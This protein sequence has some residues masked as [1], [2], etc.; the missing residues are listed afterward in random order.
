MPQQAPQSSVGSSEGQNGMGSG[1][2]QQG[3]QQQNLGGQ[4]SHLGGQGQQ[5]MGSGG[6]EQTGQRTVVHD[7]APAPTMRGETRR[8]LGGRSLFTGHRDVP[9][10]G[11]PPV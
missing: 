3:Y 4:G 2:G 11:A 1:I 8:G 6:F 10:N 7:D 5:Q 9:P